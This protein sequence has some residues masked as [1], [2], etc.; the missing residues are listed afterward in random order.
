MSHRN[1]TCL[2]SSK[3]D[4]NDIAQ[5]LVRGVWDDHISYDIV[6]LN[7]R[8]KPRLCVLGIKEK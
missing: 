7:H 6:M 4:S 2:D 8:D 1:N 5:R 3:S